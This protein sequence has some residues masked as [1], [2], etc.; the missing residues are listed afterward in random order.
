MK[1]II[2]NNKE[3][4]KEV[5]LYLKSVE[6]GVELWT[7]NGMCLMV[8]IDSKFKRIKYVEEVNVS[9]DINGRIIELDSWDELDKRKNKSYV[10]KRT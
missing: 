3:K 6:D 9:T 8:F 5:G 10:Q 1:F 2:R 4:E 7:T